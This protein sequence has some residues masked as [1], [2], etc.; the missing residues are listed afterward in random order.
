MWQVELE[1][2]TD[3]LTDAEWEALFTSTNNNTTTEEVL[4]KFKRKNAF[5]LDTMTTNA[6][7]IARFPTGKIAIHPKTVYYWIETVNGNDDYEP[8]NVPHYFVLYPDKEIV[9]LDK[10]TGD[11]YKRDV[12]GLPIGAPDG[13]DLKLAKILLC[14]CSPDHQE[15]D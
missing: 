12:D 5:K 13:A 1:E 15:E 8:E 6:D 11:T 7:G 9:W 2:D 14:R 3:L 4:A 10:E